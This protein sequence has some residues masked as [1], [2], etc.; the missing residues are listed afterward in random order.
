MEK[1]MRI[2]LLA[3]IL[4]STAM[5]GAE[6][7]Q[8][9]TRFGNSINLF[10]QNDISGFYRRDDVNTRIVGSVGTVSINE[11][12]SAQVKFRG[13]RSVLSLIGVGCT[14]LQFGKDWNTF[15]IALVYM[16]EQNME[17]NESRVTRINDEK[18][19]ESDWKDTTTSIIPMQ[20]LHFQFAEIFRIRLLPQY[21][22]TQLR[23]LCGFGFSAG[24]LWVPFG[25]G[26]KPIPAAH[27]FP[28]LGMEFHP[29]GRFSVFIEGIYSLGISREQSGGDFH[30][31]SGTL[32]TTTSI[33]YRYLIN[34]GRISAGINYYLKKV[35]SGE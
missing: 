17:L 1:N 13:R 34:G 8:S 5:S 19:T 33:R 11:T 7:S 29:N 14:F 9:K 20:F 26:K 15:R 35:Y 4:I 22:K 3:F 31:V 28:L 25:D 10:Y 23:L 21:H 2:L 27:A 32:T 6:V 12:Y 16:P 24:F 18:V 30:S